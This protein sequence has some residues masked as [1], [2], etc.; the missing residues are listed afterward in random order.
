MELLYFMCCICVQISLKLSSLSTLEGGSVIQGAPDSGIQ[1]NWL[2][3][4]NMDN[5]EYKVSIS[6]DMLLQVVLY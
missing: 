2:T 4:G 6:R 1:D 3:Q 5:T